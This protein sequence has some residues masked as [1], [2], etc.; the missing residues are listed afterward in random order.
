MNHDRENSFPII[1]RKPFP[2]IPAKAAGSD[3]TKQYPGSFWPQYNEWEKLHY[4]R[5]RLCLLI[6]V[7]IEFLRLGTFSYTYT[8][9]THTHTH[10]HAHNRMYNLYS[11]FY[12]EIGIL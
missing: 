7:L 8:T 6:T 2:D 11:Q 3:G 1:Q 5:D 10:T 9:H 4:E 12:V